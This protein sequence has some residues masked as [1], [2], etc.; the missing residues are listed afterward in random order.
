MLGSGAITEPK[1][2]HRSSAK[3]CSIQ[4]KVCTG[5]NILPF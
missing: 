2:K 1:Q 4:V 5:R 3:Y